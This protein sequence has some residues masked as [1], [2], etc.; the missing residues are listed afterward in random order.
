[1]RPAGQPSSEQNAIKFVVG[2]KVRGVFG[3]TW[4][5]GSG[6]TSFYIRPSSRGVDVKLNGC[7]GPGL[8]NG[9]VPR[10]SAV[11]VPWY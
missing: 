11:L 6:R 5:L 7:A 3:F 8:R 4:R 2:D 1:M 10:L 9:G